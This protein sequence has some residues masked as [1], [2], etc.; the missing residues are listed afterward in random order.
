MRPVNGATDVKK[1][2]RLEP[3]AAALMQ[4]IRGVGYHPRTAIADLI[5]NSIAAGATTVLVMLQWAGTDSFVSILDDGKGMDA[6]GIDLAMTLGSRTPSASRAATDLGRFGLGLKTASLSQCSRL[7]VASKR[8]GTTAV[9]IWDL[10]VV[11]ETNDWIVLDEPEPIEVEAISALDSLVS[12]TAVIWR[13]LD[14]ILGSPIRTDEESRLRF[15][16]LAIEVE[17][18]LAMTFQRFLEGSRPKLKLFINGTDEEFRI[19]PWDPFCTENPATQALPPARR[20]TEAGTVELRGFVLPHKDRLGTAAFDSAAGPAGW[21]SQQGIYVYRADRLLVAG[22]WLGLG[23][24][25]RWARDE[26]HKLARIALDIPNSADSA[27]SIDIKK[28][29]A[30]PPSDLRSWLTRQIASVRTEARE[31]FVHRGN[32]A[33]AATKAAFVPLWQQS[34][35]G[36]ASYRLNRDHPLLKAQLE[37][38]GKN[39]G[40]LELLRLIETTVPVHRIWLD[41]AESPESPSPLREQVP[42]SMILDAARDLV[43]RIARAESITLTQ[44]IARVKLIEPFDQYAAIIDGMVLSA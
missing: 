20:T 23:Q 16:Q 1:P 26:Q 17:M 25:K 30:R 8:S 28:S 27:W 13:H 18:H 29:S 32:R 11:N 14:R 34:S 22:S 39:K 36:A 37:N 44:A 12:G 9:R 41:V 40:L 33:A 24:P 31:V 35:T 38:A 6:D 7:V 4:S 3:P 43:Q 19:K 2:R 5:D 21:I 10:D 15:Q 42:D